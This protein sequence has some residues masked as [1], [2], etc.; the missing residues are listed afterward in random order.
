MKEITYCGALLFLATLAPED[1]R[2]KQISVKK[3]I[4]FGLLALICRLAAGQVQLGLGAKVACSLI[5]GAF[6]LFLSVISIESIGFGDG[7]AVMVLGLWVGGIK[8][9]IILCIAW[10]MAGAFAVICL[11]KK[12]KE[13]IPFIPFL[14]LGMEVLLFYA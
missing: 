9:F 4:I 3:I 11:I 1:I 13:P 12:W 7:M 14:L 10:T 8:T 2:E 6:L 5:P